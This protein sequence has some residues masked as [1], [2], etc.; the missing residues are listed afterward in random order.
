[1]VK[2]ALNSDF[3]NEILPIY[4][5]VSVFILTFALRYLPFR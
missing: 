1:M 5:V 2:L 3:D 4:H